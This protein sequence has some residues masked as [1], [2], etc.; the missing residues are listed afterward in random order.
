MKKILLSF[1]ILFLVGCV[2]QPV[3]KI[4]EIE[5]EPIT[6]VVEEPVVKDDV[7][8][9]PAKEKYCPG[10]CTKDYCVDSDFYRCMEAGDSCNY[11]QKVGMVI[12]QCNINCLEDDDCSWYQDC[13]INESRFAVTQ[14]CINVSDEERA[15]RE[16]AVQQG[17]PY[18]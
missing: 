12:G 8:T 17:L 1:I 16:P 15:V 7:I 5:K 3:Q 2:S 4:V 13:Q 10:A 6:A 11:A 18:R 9:M 14:L